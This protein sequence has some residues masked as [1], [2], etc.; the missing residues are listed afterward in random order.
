VLV[1]NRDLTNERELRVEWQDLVPKRVLACET[2]TG[3]ELKA[4]NTFEA[5][6]RVVPQTLP[7]PAVGGRMT[8]TL[9]PRSYTVV[10]LGL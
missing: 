8:F 3:P 1:L 6:R 4:F 7:A 5:P 10:H 9:P 2:L